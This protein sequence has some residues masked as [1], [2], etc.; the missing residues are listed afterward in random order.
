VPKLE[1]LGW[2]CSWT[3]QTH[4]ITVHTGGVQTLDTTSSLQMLR[5]WTVVASRHSHF[6]SCCGAEAHCHPTECRAWNRSRSHFFHDAY[7]SNT[8]DEAHTAS[9]WSKEMKLSWCRCLELVFVVASFQFF[10]K[11]ARPPI[12]SM[13][14]CPCAPLRLTALFDAPR[15]SNWQERLQWI[16][17]AR[18]NSP[19]P[20]RTAGVA[21]R[22]DSFC[23]SVVRQ[24]STFSQLQSTSVNFSQL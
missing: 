17:R 3:V 20:L 11:I 23:V 14:R 16:A 5:R 13:L 8:Q 4:I 9:R 19:C 18:S 22:I 24:H 12:I 6:V 7:A 15:F 21:C 2:N 1:Y 10:T